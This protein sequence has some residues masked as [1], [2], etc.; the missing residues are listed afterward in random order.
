MFE[1]LERRAPGQQ[2]QSPDSPRIAIRDNNWHRRGWLVLLRARQQPGAAARRGLLWSW[3]NYCCVKRSVD[4]G[5]VRVA[6][7]TGQEPDVEEGQG[8]VAHE[9]AV[10]GKQQV[11]M[12]VIDYQEDR[13]F[14]SVVGYL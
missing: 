1:P 10:P 9:T 11:L 4:R 8:I 2:N 13:V 7:D 14:R 6:P 5:L 3:T 12:R